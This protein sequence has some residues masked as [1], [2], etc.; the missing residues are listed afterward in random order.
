MTDLIAAHAELQE[1]YVALEAAIH[2][3][4]LDRIKQKN[5]YKRLEEQVRVLTETFSHIHAG[6]GN[7]TCRECGLDIRNPIHKREG[8]GNNG[9]S[10]SQGD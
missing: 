6:F 3:L 10:H 9:R 1:R 8:A 4:R 7:D 5:K 2:D